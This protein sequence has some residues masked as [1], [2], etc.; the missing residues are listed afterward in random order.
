MCSLGAGALPRV[1]AHAAPTSACIRATGVPVCVVT[2]VR[3]LA[4]VCACALCGRGCGGMA[5]Q[6]PCRES[7]ET[8]DHPTMW[9]VGP[10][11]SLHECCDVLAPSSGH[12]GAFVEKGRHTWHVRGL[13]VSH[14]RS[15]PHPDRGARPWGHD[16]SE[17]RTGSSVPRA[18]LALPS[19]IPR[20]DRRLWTDAPNVS[21][22]TG[23]A[24]FGSPGSVPGPRGRRSSWAT[25]VATERGEGGTGGRGQ[26]GRGEKRRDKEG[27]T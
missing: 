27:K 25:R 2:S 19:H 15:Q 11:R 12:P 1:C 16:T 26:A 9:T 7:L 23:G 24:V 10:I 18:Q 4:H 5:L 17:V 22:G 21:A 8:H 20:E 13:H 14:E 6:E 3:V